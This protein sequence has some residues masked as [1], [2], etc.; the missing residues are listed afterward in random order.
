MIR[1]RKRVRVNAR[2]PDHDGKYRD[3]MTQE[4]EIEMEDESLI[5]TTEVVGDAIN[6]ELMAMFQRIKILGGAD[7]TQTEDQE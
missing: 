7:Y 3:E 1:V 5:K 2:L 4:L 6:I